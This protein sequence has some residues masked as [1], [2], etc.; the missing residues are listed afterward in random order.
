MDGANEGTCQSQL[1]EALEWSSQLEEE[2]QESSLLQV[3]ALKLSSLKL[4]LKLSFE[5][6]P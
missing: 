1:D 4:L 2:L 3:F 5:S 6:V